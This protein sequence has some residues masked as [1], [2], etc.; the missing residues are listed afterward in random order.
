[1]RRKVMGTLLVVGCLAMA[2]GAAQQQEA[3]GRG[4]RTGGAPSADALQVETLSDKLF[5]LRGGG[6]SGNTVAF[7]TANGVTLVDTKLP[8]WG[9][10]L[11]DKLKTL[12]DK[13]VTTIINT[14][15]HNDHVSGNVEIPGKVE[16][17]THQN[18][19]I[20]MEQW[21]PVSGF[22]AAGESP[23]P[24]KASGGRGMP[25][26]TFT[27]RLT[28]GSGADQIDLHYVGRAHTGGDALVVF[29][30]ARVMAAGDIFWNKANPV[31]DSNNGGS[32][33]AFP[34]TLRK[35]AAVPNIDRVITGHG[36]TVSLAELREYADYI[37]EFVTAVQAAK[38]AGQTIDDVIKT[39]K[40]PDRFKGYAPAQALFVRANAEVIYAETP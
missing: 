1:M 6:G 24:F 14:H 19:K 22:G 5:V 39:W 17:V 9:Q 10:P 40:V 29:P 26:R 25:T 34:E 27:D 20:Y 18:T 32:G 4:G 30:I 38:K 16:I 23:N 31:I 33:V 3:A 11:L 37:Q 13:P 7:I 21:N 12:T 36:A 35:A 15:T 2:V 28:L 8:G